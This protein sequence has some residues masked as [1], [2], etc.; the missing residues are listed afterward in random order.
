MSGTYPDIAEK[1]FQDKFSELIDV[2]TLQ[3]SQSHNI[4][5]VAALSQYSY[6]A[7]RATAL[8]LQQSWPV[9]NPG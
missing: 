7:S 2:L 5:F 6:T 1:T 8:P 9:N 3:A 4:G